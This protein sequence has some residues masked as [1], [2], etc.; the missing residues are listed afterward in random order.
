MRPIQMVKRAKLTHFL[1]SKMPIMGDFVV[2]RGD[3]MPIN[4]DL[5]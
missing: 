3:S 5:A 2:A 4:T 1:G